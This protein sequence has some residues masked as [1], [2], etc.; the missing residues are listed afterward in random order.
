MT[1]FCHGVKFVVL[2]VGEG[3]V[4]ILR[5]YSLPYSP[6]HVLLFSHSPGH[7]VKIIYNITN[8]TEKIS[9]QNLKKEFRKKILSLVA[10]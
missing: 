4:I 1:S 8:I 6:L 5:C 3:G 2:E 9:K 7:S 10:C